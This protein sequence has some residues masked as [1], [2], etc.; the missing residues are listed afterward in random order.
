MSSILKV[1]TIQN[2]GGTTGLTIDSSGRLLKPVIPAFMVTYAATWATL[3]AG[4]VVP[5]NTASGGQLFNKGGHFNTT[6]NAF[7][8]PVAGLYSFSTIIYTGNS[9]TINS[10]AP[11]LNGSVVI[12]TGSQ[13]LYIQ[14]GESTALDNTTGLT[15][16]LDLAANDSIK[17]HAVSGSDIYGQ[18]SMFCGHLVG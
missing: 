8:A 3:S 9:D 5:F 10:F 18:A 15:W 1:D 11:Y 13:G 7:V 12:L 4:N 16:L 6:T 2:T 17:I 14:Q